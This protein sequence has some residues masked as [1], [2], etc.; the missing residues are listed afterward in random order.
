MVIAFS[1]LSS[2]FFV[3]AQ[4]LS[5]KCAHVHSYVVARAYAY[6]Q[7]FTRFTTH[8]LYWEVQ[9]K[10]SNDEKKEDNQGENKRTEFIAS[11]AD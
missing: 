11:Q 4:I 1:F 8:S 7:T 10:K 5:D 6:V 2:F 3:N 9:S